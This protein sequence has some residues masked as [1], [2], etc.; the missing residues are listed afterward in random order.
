MGSKR[1]REY[2]IEIGTLPTGPTNHLCD[3]P[4]VLVGHVT[5]DRDH[6]YGNEVCT[7]V[8]AILPHKGNWFRD[9]VPA[10]SH[11]ING[12]GKTTGTIQVNELGLLG[13]P[14]MLTNTFGVPA[15]TEGVLPKPGVK[16][17]SSDMGI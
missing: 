2:G 3:V 15:V 4:G 11:V 5:L 10:A 9:P 8:T 14:I 7:G 13:S 12:Y 16:P 17:L 6:R 1:L